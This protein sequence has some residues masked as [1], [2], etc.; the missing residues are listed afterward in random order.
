MVHT[1][2]DTYRKLPVVIV[3][4]KWAYSAFQLVINWNFHP[5]MLNKVGHDYVHNNCVMI[6]SVHVHVHCITHVHVS[7]ESLGFIAIAI[8][9]PNFIYCQRLVLCYPIYY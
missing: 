9:E 8:L 7:K 4:T 3:I 6:Y 1:V 5:S 2:H